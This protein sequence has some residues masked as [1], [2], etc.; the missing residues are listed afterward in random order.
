MRS[1]VQVKTLAPIL[2]LSLGLV[3]LACGMLWTD[4]F[5]GETTWTEDKSAR[6]MELSNRSHSLLVSTQ[7][8]EQNPSMHAGQ[9]VA[10]LEEEFSQ[11]RGE[12]E[13]LREEY[14]T[15]RDR[16][17]WLARLLRWVGGTLTAI[18]IVC[19]LAVREG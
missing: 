19:C 8:R 10:E 11:V 15:A 4:V 5:V 2:G 18:G 9:N 7:L 1:R 13:V 16:P 17:E 12:L 6:M 3:F 14:E